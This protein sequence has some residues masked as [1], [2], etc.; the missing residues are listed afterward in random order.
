MGGL[1]GDAAD[2]VVEDEVS[3]GGGLVVVLGVVWVFGVGEVGELVTGGLAGV[4]FLVSEF[5]VEFGAHL[6][7]A[8]V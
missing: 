6:D 5:L 1:G 7:L 3:G 8:A 4:G 2:A